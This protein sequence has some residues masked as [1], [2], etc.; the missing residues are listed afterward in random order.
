MSNR[1][2]TRERTR[3]SD[4]VDA[5]LMGFAIKIRV[6]AVHP[7]HVDAVLNAV[8]A[9][10]DLPSPLPQ[11]HEGRK[12]GHLA[13]VQV[14]GIK[15]SA[16]AAAHAGCISSPQEPEQV[17]GAEG[18]ASRGQH[19]PEALRTQPWYP[20]RPGDVVLHTAWDGTSR[21]YL[22]ED[23]ADQADP[24][25]SPLLREVSSSATPPRRKRTSV[26]DPR[27]TKPVDLDMLL[28]GG[29]VRLYPLW[30]DS[31]PTTLTIIRAGH[32]LYGSPARPSA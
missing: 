11:A 25:R 31:S 9:V 8:D 5:P 17:P 6:E 10:L 12:G 28:T 13:Y 15:E 22:A 26:D 29:L 14:G 24:D 1:R 7:A 2:P 23:E 21:T 4:R 16:V 27:D 20:L 30:C 3:A 18:T 32:I 19:D